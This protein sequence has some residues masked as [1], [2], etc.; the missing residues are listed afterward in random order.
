MTIFIICLV[1]IAAGAFFLWRV[2][3]DISQYH[4]RITT[5][6][7]D[8]TG[9]SITTGKVTLRILPAPYIEVHDIK[10]NLDDGEFLRSRLMKFRVSILPFF[11]KKVVLQKVVMQGWSLNIRRDRDGAMALRKMYERI[12][13]RKHIISVQDL[14]LLAGELFLEDKA[15]GRD[16]RLKAQLNNGTAR[17]SDYGLSFQADLSLEDGANLYTRGS[18]RKEGEKIGLRGQV[19]IS[20]LS[21]STLTSYI[22]TPAV[23]GSV[24]GDLAFSLG[25]II[26]LRG[27][28]NYKNITLNLPSLRKAPVDS[29]SGK[30]YLDL[31][32]ADDYL[33]LQAKK[34]ELAIEDFVLSGS[35][36]LGGAPSKTD[37]MA[38][39]FNLKCT[40]IPLKD[41]KAHVLNKILT[42]KLSWI[43][44]FTPTGGAVRIE[45]F[46]LGATVKELRDGK[47]FS[48]PGAMRLDAEF[49]DI[50]LRHTLLKED[51][52]GLKGK[53]TLTDNSINFHDI[54]SKLGR[55]YVEKLS[56]RMNDLH[57]TKKAASYDLSILGHMDA[58]RAI[59]MTIRVFRDSGKSAKKQLRRIAATGETR[60]K[61]NLKGK[62]DVKDSTWFSVNL[63]LH[64]ATF[65]YKGFPLSFTSMNGNID[66]DSHR[67]TFTDL[68]LRDSAAS[69][70]R[71][72]GYVRDYTLKNPYFHLNTEGR[73]FNGT[74][75]AFTEKT[76][77]DEIIMDETLLFH[78]TIVG[79]KK[80]LK[81]NAGVDLGKA[82]LE[83]RKLLKKS[84]SIPL[85]MDAEFIVKDKTI[86][87]K[88]ASISTAAS[89][90]DING[91]LSRGKG[92]YS[93][94]INSKKLRLYDLADLTPLIIK[95]ADT[96]G[97][98][99]VI[100][101]VSK[102]PGDKRPAYKG[103]I[104]VKNAAFSS[105]VIKEP[106]KTFELSM[107]FDDDKA[108]L[109]I[110]ELKFG[111]SDI[112]GSLDI[113]S[114]SK[115]GIT[116]NL[117]SNMLETN[118]IWGDGE[119]DGLKA[120]LLKMRS[121]GIIKKKDTSKRA[122][123]SGSGKISIAKGR[124]FDEEIRDFKAVTLFRPE[125]ISLDPIVFLTEGGT[126]TGTTVF[127]RADKSPELF[128]ASAEISGIHLKDA[129]DRL[130]ATKEML[131]GT[132]YGDIKIRCARGEAHF[133]R[134]LNGNGFFKAERG[135]MWKFPVISKIF[136]IVNII[137]I[138]ELFKKGLPYKSLKADV[139]I[140]DGIFSTDNLLFES[141][142][143]KMSA[144]MDID[145]TK[146]TINA[147]LGVHPF[148]TIDKL[149]TSIPLVGWIMGGDEKSSLSL[150]YNINGPLTKPDVEPAM[151]KNMQKGIL[152]KLERLITS[153][154]KIIQ[155]SN[156]MINHKDKG[157]NNGG[158]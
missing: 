37:D 90:I 158:R 51:I 47:A 30:A 35:M 25:D 107:N 120:W 86:D 36:D 129:L 70:L 153:P 68:I 94:F 11:R 49:V 29:P 63:G 154:I 87:I 84:S 39:T 24:S 77:L 115:T 62:I 44:D 109:N 4:D 82:G 102:K 152:G 85:A 8:I 79:L 99:K 121:L 150:Y 133:T 7:E 32:L 110:P 146:S 72:E 66:V 76:A 20:D 18:A 125:T 141:D 56:Y 97:L 2:P 145:S 31:K 23:K 54:S 92:P 132:L 83:Y 124:I 118:D 151:I 105:P 67:F 148:V 64:G 106:I 128:E 96:A 149:V 112:Y 41:V 135:R 131:T 71:I 140:T 100:L 88:K 75:S 59:A 108:K 119:D 19:T 103:L 113:N 13:K 91:Y 38:L 127:Y 93:L 5:S 156:D 17:L 22:K 60:I 40:P 33:K 95:K 101:K 73:V 143:M 27:P 3:L 114:I 157:G 116:F 28:V 122:T 15:K 48:L 53:L 45:N 21:V 42:K 16:L 147:T 61:F 117:S 126:V 138:D 123:L 50:G 57:S 130:G 58:G 137:S 55:G 144:V 81:V 46:T 43:N 69:N 80:S 9:G 52:G 134:C 26:E 142:S 139:N 89:S 1:I 136:S 6:L 14:R 111:E 12:I 74:L 98:L 34:A 10:M 78:S 155:E 65:R 104:S